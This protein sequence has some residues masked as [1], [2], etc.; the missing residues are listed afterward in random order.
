MSASLVMF[1]VDGER[2]DFPINKQTVILGRK[3]S[4]DLRIPLSS[5]SR[6]HCQIERRDDGI[7]LR[8]LGSSN[9]T[10]HNN[11]RVHEVKLEPGDKVVVGPVHFTVVIDGEPAEVEPVQTIMP[12]GAGEV[13]DSVVEPAARKPAA[14]EVEEIA[15]V[16][17]IDDLDDEPIAEVE[18]IE[19]IP[20]FSKRAARPDSPVAHQSDEGDA[21]PDIVVEPQVQAADSEDDEDPIAA[22]EKLMAGGNADDDGPVFDFDDDESDDSVPLFDDEDER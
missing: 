17:A 22:L 16:E 1:K 5:V 3:H 8:D 18:E 19:E 13:D 7:Y 2:R 20:D 14:D 10:Y 21:E 4:C 15:E 12:A 11:N 6:E 9:G